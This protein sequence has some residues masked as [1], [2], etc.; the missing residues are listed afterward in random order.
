M[1]DERVS[2]TAVVEVVLGCPPGA[3]CAEQHTVLASL[4]LSITAPDAP[5]TTSQPGPD[6][7]TV[8]STLLYTQSGTLTS[9]VGST[10]VQTGSETVTVTVS[11]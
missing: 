7:D 10:P 11:P 6:P 1:T 3:Y 9:M 2:G 4:T 8:R 5:I